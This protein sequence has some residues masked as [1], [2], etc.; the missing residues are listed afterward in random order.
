MTLED[1]LNKALQILNT[2]STDGVPISNAFNNQ[3]DLKLRL[4]GFANDAQQEIARTNGRITREFTIVTFENDIAFSTQIESVTMVHGGTSTFSGNGGHSYSI[5]VS[6]SCTV[7]V[8]VGGN[9]VKSET[10]YPT[11]GQFVCVKGVVSN[12]GNQTLTI[13]VSSEYDYL[14]KNVAIFK[15]KFCCVRSTHPCFVLDFLSN[16][17]S[18]KTFF[19]DKCRDL[20]STV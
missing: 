14:Y 19:Y 18:F 9:V 1:A 15:N 11:A 8:S 7:D 16:R 12:P 3:A 6:G 13:T 17:K 5:N 10:V 4:R 2:Y 20:C